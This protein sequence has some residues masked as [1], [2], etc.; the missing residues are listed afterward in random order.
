MPLRVIKVGRNGNHHFTNRFFQRRFC[1][2]AL[3]SALI[4]ALR[5]DAELF[6]ALPVVMLSAFPLVQIVH[7]LPALPRAEAA[8]SAHSKAII[9]Y[10]LLAWMF[11]IAVR[12]VYVC[13]DPH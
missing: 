13:S 5:R 9:E 3:T 7:V 11:V 12:A 1:T 2:I 8:L 10:V 6:L 4:A